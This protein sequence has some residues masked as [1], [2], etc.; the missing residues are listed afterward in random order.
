MWWAP[1]VN[2]LFSFST[3]PLSLL[4]FFSIAEDELVPA[5]TKAV[6]GMVTPISRSDRPAL[7]PLPLGRA[8]MR[9]PGE[10]LRDHVHDKSRLIDA[11]LEH[12]RELVTECVHLLARAS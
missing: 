6:H 12:V 9:T 4:A 3:S 10:H 8:R 11:T 1:H 5:L 2:F 7:A